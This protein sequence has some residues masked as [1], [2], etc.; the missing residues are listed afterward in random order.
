MVLYKLR[1]REAKTSRTWRIGDPFLKGDNIITTSG[2]LELTE[3]K[4][5]IGSGGVERVICCNS[6]TWYLQALAKQSCSAV[7][8]YEL[9]IALVST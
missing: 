8:Q 2:P 3:V 7:F 9:Y 4:G 5:I 6:C 1:C